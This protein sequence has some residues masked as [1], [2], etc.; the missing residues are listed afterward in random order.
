LLNTE[1][2]ARLIAADPKQ[3]YLHDD[4]LLVEVSLALPI[5]QAVACARDLHAR[6]YRGDEI[7][8][9][10]IERLVRSVVQ[11][12]LQATGLGAPPT[13]YIRRSGGPS[14]AAVPDWTTTTIE[15]VGEAADPDVR[16][17]QGKLRASRAAELDA[18]R[19]LAE[20]IAGL[21]VDEER[22]VRDVAGSYGA[23]LRI[24]ALAAEA[25]V[26]STRFTGD[27]AIVTVSAPGMRI[28]SVVS[29]LRS[30]GAARR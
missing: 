3:E 30:G 26:S 8:S 15:A 24:D 19:M 17:P 22:C 20:Q 23:A 5:E 10:D 18:R 27:K 11:S 21:K 14:A 6:H 7:E 9:A 28:W 16:T 2:S 1:L 25:I 4:A 29:D 13:V 12:E